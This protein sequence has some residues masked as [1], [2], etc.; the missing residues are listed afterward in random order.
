MRIVIHDYAGHPGEIYMSRELARRGNEV[1]HLYAGSI[2]T[3]RGEL[4]ITPDDPPTFKVEGI[5]LDKPFRKHTYVRR[6]LQE[7]EYGR[8]LVDAI[9]KFKPDVVLSANTPLFPQARLARACRKWGVGFVFWVMDV[10]GLAVDAALRGKLPVIGGLVGSYYIWLEKQLLRASDQ[11]ILISEGFAPTIESWGVPREKLQIVPLW[12]PLDELP[13]LPKDNDWSRQN[14]FDQTINLIYAGTLGSKHNPETLVALAQQLKAREDVRIIVVSEGVGSEYLKKRKME[15]PLEHL[16]LLPYQ[17]YD[18]L[19]QVLASADVL[20]AL[21]EP[22]AG[23]FSVPGKVL[24]H[25]CAQRP[26]VAAV[27]MINRAAKVIQDSGGGFAIPVG[28]DAAFVDAVV[29]LIDDP[30]LRREMGLK[31]R[32]YADTEFDIGRIG[33]RVEGVLKLVMPNVSRK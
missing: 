32:A 21:L 17:P 3:P 7:I 28:D 23:A 8:L 20:L 15:T 13:V 24:S 25:L 10:Y 11:V 2:E 14:G 31:S 5:F 33:E 19:A 18:Q 26:Q 29:T 6:Q 16:V 30:E 22:S 12:P 27:P 1:L 9:G 4:Q